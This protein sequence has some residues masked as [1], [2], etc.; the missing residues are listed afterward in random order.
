MQRNR[1]VIDCDPGIDDTFALILCIKKLDVAGIVA[2]G[3]NT[4]LQFTSRNARYVTE[5]TG[6]TDIPVYAGYDQPMLGNAVRAE[7]VHGVG[8]L[9]GSRYSGAE[10]AVG[11]RTWVWIF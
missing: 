6:R 8:G 3:G 4:G 11:K 9:G 7:Y 10:K 2:V 1:I 5:L